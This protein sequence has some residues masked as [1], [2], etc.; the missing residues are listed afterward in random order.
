[1]NSN[2]K[3]FATWSDDQ[4]RDKAFSQAGDM[5]SENT[6]I[7][8]NKAIGTNYR[9]YIDIEPDRSVRT[10]MSK[11]DYTRFRP[12]ESVPYMQKRIMRACL[13]AYDKV[14]IVRNVVDLMS[15]FSS[16]GI[17]IV[18]P[19]KAIEKF[20]QRWWREVKGQDRSERFANLFYKTGNVVV[21]RSMAKISASKEDELKKSAASDIEIQ[22]IKYPKREIPWRY[23]FLNPLS[24][25]V[26]NYYSGGFIG[27]P[28]YVMNLG[29]FGSD[30]MSA[31]KNSF[32]KLPPEIQ[33]RVK[34]GQTTIPLDQNRIEVFFYKKDDWQLWANPMLYAILD[35]L[36]MLEKM[37]L[38]DLAALDG[39]ISQIRLWTLG[40]LE[41]KIIPKKELIARLR[42]I[43]ASHTGGGTMDLVWGPELTFKES[44]SKVYQFLGSQKYE[45]VLNQIYGGLGIPPTLTGSSSGAGMT[46]NHLSL[47][48]LIK[49]LEYG[50]SVLSDFWKKEI[51]IVQKAM[52]FRFPAEIKFENI[53]LSDEAAIKK[54]WLEMVDRNIVS[55]ETMVEAIGEIP[56]IERIRLRRQEKYRRDDS[57]AS[58]KASPFHNPNIKN[59]IAKI[60]VTKDAIDD[61][62]YESFDLPKIDVP[63]PPSPA[64]KVG[65]PVSKKP[66]KS[67][68][69]G[70][71]PL[72]TKDSQ[73]RKTKRVLPRTGKTTASLWA[74]N[75]QKTIS[76]MVTPMILAFYEKKDVRS[77]T[78][79]Q[80]DYLEYFKLCLLT[81]IE[82]F[83]EIT[84][85][86]IK[87]LIDNSHKPSQH[88]KDLVTAKV[89][90]FV[91]INDR[92]P[93]LDELK[94]IYSD[95]YVDEVFDEDISS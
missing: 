19:N 52:G 33:Q 46:N 32:D 94:H 27:D 57:L 39:A 36:I 60:L 14:G 4:G 78:K 21:Q 95:A 85:E 91:Y 28:V 30:L 6:S 18:H 90:D 53:I 26:E 64:G 15:D 72:S 81:G 20:Y 13:D 84:P 37:K 69:K 67:G 71:R 3:L 31:Y 74:Y 25:D 40:S 83:I 50:R 12:E 75:A 68:L 82:P 43:L 73:K 29:S 66:K 24:I 17:S 86:I 87:E 47:N 88:F 34:K 49:R 54:L 7:Q 92:K 16:H 8:K 76:D 23:E 44:E 2:N 22:N 11:F 41:Y 61:K 42:N 9:T 77:L 48:T 65:S 79:S 55:E 35:D 56:E 62:Y 10:S 70:G 51:E 80:T 59:D 63:I 93:N 58:Q 1:M 5:Y 45:P 38:A 89:K